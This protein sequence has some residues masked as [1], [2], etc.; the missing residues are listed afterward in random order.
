MK[1]WLTVFAALITIVLIGAACQKNTK[2]TS[3]DVG[4]PA[5]ENTGVVDENANLNEDV[6]GVRENVNALPVDNGNVNENV[7]VQNSNENTNVPVNYGTITVEQ[8]KKDDNLTSPFTVKGTAQGST[9]FVRVKNASGDTMFTEPVQVR[10]NTFSISLTFDVSRSTTGTIEVFDKDASG[11]VQNLMVIPVS[12]V[13][14]T[15][16][17]NLN[18]NENV[19]EN[20]KAN[21]N[22]NENANVNY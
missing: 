4:I 6:T 18:V 2:N 7:N 3:D 19:N 15:T 8:P 13:S 22:L 16:G 10:Q 1:K 21:E 14:G 20:T 5:N 12:F 9:V 17:T 11:N